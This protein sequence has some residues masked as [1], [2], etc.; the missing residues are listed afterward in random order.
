VSGLLQDHKELTTELCKVSCR[1]LI[2]AHQG[3]SCKGSCRAPAGLLQRSHPEETPAQECS[4]QG[5]LQIT[6]GGGS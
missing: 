5:L 2:E 3:L 1:V 6:A 4:C